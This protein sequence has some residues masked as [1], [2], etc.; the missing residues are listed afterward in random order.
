MLPCSTILRVGPA[1]TTAFTSNKVANFDRP[2]IAAINGYALGGGAELSLCCD[3]RIARS[4]AKIGFP[5]V[6]LGG[7]PGYTGPSRAVKILGPAVAK[8]MLFTGRRYTA[9]EALSRHFVTEVVEPEQLLERAE[10]IM[11]EILERSPIAV[12]FGKMMCDRCAEMSY[13]ASLEY[14]RVICAL[15]PYAEDYKEGHDAF[16][17]KR[18]PKFVNN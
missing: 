9:E 16:L 18:P 13:E 4:K 15:L 7:I 1:G 2:V 14:E 3:I 12:K 10:E 11:N 8:E 5:E 17:E 6:R